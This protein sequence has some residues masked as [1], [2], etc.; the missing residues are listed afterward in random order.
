LYSTTKKIEEKHPIIKP[1]QDSS[2][3]SFNIKLA[4]GRIFSAKKVYNKRHPNIETLCTKASFEMRTGMATKA[5]LRKQATSSHSA[6]ALEY[7]EVRN[8]NIWL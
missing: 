6:H 3:I 8:P 1:M 5:I 7:M 4:M 2:S